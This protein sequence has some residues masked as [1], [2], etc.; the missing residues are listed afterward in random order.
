[1]KDVSIE[2]SESYELVLMVI[3]DMREWIGVTQIAKIS[4]VSPKKTKALLEEMMQNQVV[5]VK[6]VGN[7]ILFGK[8]SL[9]AR[10]AALAKL[11]DTEF[12]KAK[13]VFECWPH[14]LKGEARKAYRAFPNPLPALAMLSRG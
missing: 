1:M 11:P 6:T 4:G 14:L 7:K 5:F 8:K 10:D 13:S 3:E 9:A 12:K 2:Q